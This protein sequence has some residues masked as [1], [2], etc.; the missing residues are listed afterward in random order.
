MQVTITNA[1]TKKVYVSMLW[2]S[3]DVGKSQTVSRTQAQLDAETQLKDLVVAGT[4]TLTF[5]AEASD[6]GVQG[7][8][9]LPSYTDANRP[10]PEDMPSGATI[11]NSADLKTNISDGTDWKDPAGATT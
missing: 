2:G 5:L 10:A 7:P 11:F 1:D 3:I 8:V 9:Q 6:A 4:V